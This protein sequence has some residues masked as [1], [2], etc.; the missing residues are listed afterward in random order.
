MAFIKYLKSKLLSGHERSVRAKKNIVGLLFARGYSVLINL[1]LIP[2]TLSLLD[3]YKYGVWITLFNVLS[4][5]S[6]FD[7]GIGH[8]L[9]NKLAEYMALGNIKEAQEYVS[10]GYVIIGTIAL[11][12][13]LLFIAPWMLLDW[14]KIFNV[15]QELANEISFLV[16]IS[17][18]LLCIQFGL[19]LINTLLTADHKPALSA[20][21]MSLSNTLIL[22]TFVLGKVYIADSLI[23]IGIVYSGIPIIVLLFMNVILFSGKYRTV[24]PKLRLYKKE[25]VKDLFNLGVQFFIIQI[26]CIV[27]FQTD[28][29]IITHKISPEA[30][31]PY[32]I[33]LYYYG[34]PL[35]CIHRGSYKK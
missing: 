14:A 9:R 21:I 7:I 12:L 6:I 26:A 16:G 15:K 3:D 24:K 31:T 17:F 33:C 20:L 22:L 8:G 35:E 25:K 10:T 1:A 34:S 29:M 4:W 23:A 32:N 11:G 13:I 27:I 30:V 18:L 19:K 2:L 5:I 28:S